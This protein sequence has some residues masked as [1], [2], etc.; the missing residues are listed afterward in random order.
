MSGGKPSLE[1]RS[2][3]RHRTRLRSGKVLNL[4]GGFLIDCQVSDVAS[5]GAKIRVPDPMRVPDRFFLFDDQHEQALM[6]EVVWRKGP[7]LGVKF[8]NDPSIAPL[9]PVRLSELAGKYYSL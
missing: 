2:A 8:C 1:K 3:A 6:A 9:D 5:G 4:H 7:E